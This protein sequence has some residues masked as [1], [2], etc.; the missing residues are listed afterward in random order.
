MFLSDKYKIQNLDDI[1]FNNF[2]YKEYLLQLTNNMQNLILHGYECSG[3]KT[4]INFL[5]QKLYGEGCLNT[6]EN[7]YTINNYGSNIVKIKLQQSKFHIVLNSNNSAIDKYII[8]EVII[9][10][11]KKNDL[12]YYKCNVPFKCI[13]IYKADLLSSQA[14]F[15]LRRIVEEF[16]YCRFILICR[17]IC[18]LIEPI[19]HRFIE[20]KFSCPTINEQKNILEEIS[21]LDNITI[22][23]TEIN[24]LV[25]IGNRNLKKNLFLLECHKYNISYK[26]NWI[27]VLDKIF[28]FLKED[29]TDKFYEIRD[30]LG[31]LFITNLDSE[32]IMN[33]LVKKVILEITDQKKLLQIL[34]IIVK[35][36]SRLKIA[37]RYIL[38][39]EALIY[40]ISIILI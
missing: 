6:K 4:F 15:A 13:I 36:D 33:Y 10:F 7:E 20:I 27:L 21:R 23:K 11:C 35:Y 14:Q 39:L 9:E 28:F 30:L 19:R 16:T 3:K 22:S 40:N 8:Q 17:N 31:E 5:L 1:K 38:H 25:K 2:L 18:S 24:N 32:T 34:N 29:V 26:C 12:Y 37:T